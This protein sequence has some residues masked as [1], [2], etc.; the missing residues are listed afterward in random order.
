MKEEIEKK[1]NYCLNCKVKPCSKKGCPL[2]NNI[3]EFIESLKKEEYVEAYKILSET[4]VLSGICGKICPHDKQCQGACVRGI[5]GEPVSIGELENY[6]YE[7]AYEQNYRLVDCYETKEKKNKKVAIIGGGPSGLTCAAFLAKEGIDVT[8]YEKYKYLGGLLVFGIPNF[9]LN[10]SRVEEV[11]NQILEL[12]IKVEYEKELGRNLNL[13]ELE[14]K[15]DAIFLSIGANKSTKMGVE[16][17][18]LN[19]VYGGNELLEYNLHPNYKN[20]NVAIIGG[21][22]VAIDCARTI[23][24]LGARKVTI[25]YR[26]EEE[27]MPAERKEIE[28]AKK[29][30]IEF[31]FKNNIV[32]IIGEKSVEKIEIIKT[33]LIKKEGEER[34]FPINIENSNYIIDMDYVIMALGSKTSEIV[35]K[36]GLELNKWGNI[37]IDEKY[38]TSKEKIYAGGDLAGIKGTVAWA[39]YSG[40]EA[41]K[42]ILIDIIG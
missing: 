33:E 14:K 26:R 12:G 9:R 11:I 15:Y 28:E 42:N 40:R 4:T 37:K 30:G 13:E 5:K 7:R 18:E 36:L 19:G 41:A 32:K 23:K 38:R 34:L 2:H 35:S 3:P 20:K 22:N 24:K 25:I 17:E 29:E 6:A 21:G 8:I 10:K 16:G 1:L 27:Q 39:A 31:A